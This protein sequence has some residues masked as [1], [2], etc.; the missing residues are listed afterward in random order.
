MPPA[1][2]QMLNASKAT[3]AR[4]AISTTSAIASYSSQCQLFESMTAFRRRAC[5]YK[6]R[7]G[8]LPIRLLAMIRWSRQAGAA[9]GSV[10]RSGASRS[11]SPAMP[12]SVKRGL[13]AHLSPQLVTV[14][15]ACLHQTRT[16][17]DRCC[18]IACNIYHTVVRLVLDT[19]AMVAAIRSEP[20][21]RGDCCLQR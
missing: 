13:G 2:I 4:L 16:K 17:N 15:G 18:N 14:G 9:L 21:L 7:C 5:S 3:A 11:S 10:P 1:G 20:A 19:A 8:S 12:T 6:L